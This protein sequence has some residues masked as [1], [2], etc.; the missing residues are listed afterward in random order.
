MITIWKLN[1]IEKFKI[2]KYKLSKISL[3]TEASS[4]SDV[5]ALLVY[6]HK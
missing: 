1:P 5:S 2:W 6:N 4:V 3:P